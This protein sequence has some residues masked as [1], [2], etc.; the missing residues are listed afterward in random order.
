M[1][2]HLQFFADGKVEKFVVY[3][4]LPSASATCVCTTLH[5]LTTAHETTFFG[6]RATSSI[7]MYI[8]IS[9]ERERERESERA[10]ERARERD[11]LFVEQKGCSTRETYTHASQDSY[12]L[13]SMVCQLKRKA[14]KDYLGNL[15][16]PKAFQE[17]Y[18]LG[19]HMPRNS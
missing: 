11:N 14:A 5:G 13:C 17:I 8:Y 9:V 4:I 10:R 6:R 3:I 1:E 16:L 7:N 19:N 2:N 18:Y 12:P 15:S